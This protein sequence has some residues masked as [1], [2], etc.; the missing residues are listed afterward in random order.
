MSI[1]DKIKSSSST[2]FSFELLP[3]L[4]G[5]GIASVFK[6]IDLLREFDPKYINITTHRSEVIF[7][8]NDQGLFEQSDVRRR[9]GTVAIAAAI[10][11]KY[12]IPVVPHVICSGFT[13]EEIEYELIDLQFLGIT[14]LLLLRGDKAKH[15]KDFVPTGHMHATDLQQQVN[16]F[17]KGIFLDGS[18]M[19]ALP[20]EPFSYG[21]AAYPERH[22]ESPNTESDL[23]YT[24]MKVDG[25]AEYLVTQMFF[26]NQKYYDFVEKCRNMGITVPIIP[27]IKPITLM[28][29]LTV[30]PKIFHTEIP[31]E[32]ASEL[33]KCKTDAEATEVGVEWCT[34]QASDLKAHGVP[35]IHFYSLMA[36]QSVKRVAKAVF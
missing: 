12:K 1:V 27:G 3:P 15:E 11:S 34:K 32:F 19:K 9:P 14:D 5:D 10:K 23:Y 36:A 28:N 22:E 4:K 35:S 21:M 17:N 25:G 31:E 6:T 18:R 26:D 20:A 8:Q 24:K 33:R 2:A 29:Q 7:K 16:N 30:L 13:K